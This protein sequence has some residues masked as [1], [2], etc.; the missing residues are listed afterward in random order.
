MRASG[1][2][3][4]R[5]NRP[6]FARFNEPFRPVIGNT[7]ELINVLI[8]SSPR[9]DQ[10]TTDR[11]GEGLRVSPHRRSSSDRMNIDPIEAA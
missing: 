6:T 3:T 11:A 1:E 2:T 7:G 9:S 10:P 5:Q 8:V 4:P